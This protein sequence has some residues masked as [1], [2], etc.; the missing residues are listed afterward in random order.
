MIVPTKLK[1]LARFVRNPSFALYHVDSD[2]WAQRQRNVL[3]DPDNR[4]IVRVEGAGEVDP[5]GRCRMH[6]G[7]LVYNQYYCEEHFSIVRENGGVHEP[8]EERVFSVVLHD[9]PRGGRMLE[10]GSYWSFYSL[11]FASAV[12]NAKNWMIE[13][14][15]EN[16]ELGRR[17]FHLN[18]RSGVFTWAYAG[19]QSQDGEPPTV[20]VDQYLAQHGIPSLDILHSDIQGGEATMLDGAAESLASKSIRYVFVST[21]SNALHQLCREKLTRY[22]YEIIAS[23]NCYES[24]CF[25]GIL[26]A[27]DPGS[28]RTTP[29]NISNRK[30]LRYARLRR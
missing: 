3:R 9:V 26:V 19:R 10:L 13:P 5:A 20:S 28:T 6:N 27:R 21:H 18:S 25:D 7:V 30:R 22:G 17:N 11:W 14:N 8:Q 4:F 15:Q 2:D 1:K 29:V 16:L 24:F 12:E 23:A